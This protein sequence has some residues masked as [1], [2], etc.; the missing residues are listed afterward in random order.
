MWNSTKF[1]GQ[2]IDAVRETLFEA[3]ILVVLVISCSS[4]N[5]GQR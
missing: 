5:G 3:A 4:K 2:S 1:I